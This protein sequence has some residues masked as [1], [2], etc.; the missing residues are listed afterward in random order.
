MNDTYAFI[1]AEKTTHGVA[2]LCRL[3]KALSSF[4]A[5][6]AAAKARSARKAADEVLAHEITVIHV[7]PVTPTGSRAFMPSCSAWG[8]A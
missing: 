8:D 3:L 2:F 1:E 7:A 5:W 6:L 4:Y